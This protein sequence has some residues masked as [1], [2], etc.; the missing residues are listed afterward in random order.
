MPAPYP[1]QFREGVVQ[2]A[3]STED[4]VILV[5]VAKDFGVHEMSLRKWI[6]KA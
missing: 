3:R 5:Q 6:H 1:Q 2:V 4:D